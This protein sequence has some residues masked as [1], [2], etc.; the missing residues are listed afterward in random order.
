VR[1]RVALIV[2]L[3][4]AFTATACTKHSAP[5]PAPN[6]SASPISW[7][8]CTSRA[9]G[10]NSSLPTNIKFDCG[11]VRVPKDWHHPDNGET[12]KIA[13]M[14]ARALD[15]NKRQG[16]V[17]MNPGGPGGS[18]VDYLPNLVPDLTNLLQHFDIVG[19]DPRG[20]GS[21]DTVRCIADSD[22]DKNFAYEPD[23]VSQSSWDGWVALQRRMADS[24]QTKF[25]EDLTLYAT[26]QAAQ[27][28]DVVRSAL[29]DQKFTYLGF[30]YG[31]LLGAVYAQLH[32]E[33]VRAMVLDGAVDPTATS[34]EAAEGQA[35]GFQQALTNFTTW[36]A[37]NARQCDIAA[38]PQGQVTKALTTA[39]TNPVKA[40][41]GRAVT[42]GLVFYGIV[43]AL[44]SQQIWSYLGSAIQDLNGGDPTAI[45]RL[46]DF[47][48]ER[49]TSGHYSTLFNAANSAVNCADADYPTVDEARA[50]QSQWRAKY[51]L[52]GGFMAAGITTCAVWPAKKD[53]YPTGTA[54]CAP[55]ILVVGTT[56]DP[57][58]PYASTQKLADML[59]VGQVLTWEGS[60]H[61][62]YPDT[63][64][65]RNAVDNYLIN[66]TLP[67]KGLRCPPSS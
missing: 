6:G 4:V 52:F 12:L 58:T 56:G 61:T 18:G 30:S 31:T 2:A 38:D 37:G 45:L 40:R 25:G 43:E 29:G 51:P 62:A 27:D 65:I 63:T 32:P 34:T 39:Q 59:G 28:M 64:C 35:K 66:L 44:Y 23:P 16:S 54:K 10:L 48:T 26:V 49:D 15:P 55:P 3:V 41:D 20:V 19:F 24:C 47:Y 33:N 5:E 46:S 53:P 14:R 36:C 17:V 9:R 1:H 60:Q 13:L 7:T 57:A 22:L 8:D 21:S 11:D 42:K 67:A 50:L